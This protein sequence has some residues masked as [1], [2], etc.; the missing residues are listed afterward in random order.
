MIRGLPAPPSVVNKKT[1]K[2]LT[3]TPV[4][5]RTMDDFEDYHAALQRFFPNL[6]AKLPKLGAKKGTFTLFSAEK[7]KSRTA[8]LNAYI[9]ALFRMPPKVIQSIITRKFLEKPR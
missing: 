3:F 1:G 8:E 9:G 4:V 7:Q 6:K 5:Y 2:P